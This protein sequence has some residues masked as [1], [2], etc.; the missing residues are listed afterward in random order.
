MNPAG[1]RNPAGFYWIIPQSRG[2]EKTRDLVNCTGG[3][4]D[5]LKCVFNSYIQGKTA[6]HKA[7]EKGDLA[8]IKFLINNGAV[9]D[10]KDIENGRTPLHMATMHRDD[11][12]IL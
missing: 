11:G 7:A 4:L 8:M 10:V 6:L 5:N 9:T 1:S 3:E 2:I 12:R